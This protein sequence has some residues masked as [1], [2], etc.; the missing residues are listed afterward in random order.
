[1]SRLALLAVAALALAGCGSSAHTV[2]VTSSGSAGAGPSATA[3][4]ATANDPAT[5]AGAGR[6][7]SASG[8][9]SSATAPSPPRFDASADAICSS[10]RAA[11]GSAGH[12]TTLVAQ[13]QVFNTVVGNA[14]RAV[15]RLR[16]LPVPAADAAEFGRFISLTAAAIKDFVDAQGRSRATSESSG[17][18]TES[19]DFAAFQ[20]AGRAAVAAG[21]AARGI[22]LH[23]C[24]S[25]GSDWL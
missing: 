10:Y 25:A 8:A 2:T 5:S 16:A 6:S 3:S 15:A 14:E 7:G 17:V 4:H 9:T 22:G 19:Q 18:V 23:V 11:V 24:G 1:M 21:A 12:A 20:R 13:E